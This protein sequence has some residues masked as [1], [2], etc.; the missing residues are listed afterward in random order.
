M[1]LVVLRFLD[2][3]IFSV[4]VLDRSSEALGCEGVAADGVGVCGA[5]SD[6]TVI[7]SFEVGMGVS[8]VCFFESLNLGGMT[9]RYAANRDS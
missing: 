7:S 4:G 5:E 1:S 8:L 6:I 2:F 3:V 9:M